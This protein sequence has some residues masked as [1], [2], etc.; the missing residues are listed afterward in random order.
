V[1]QADVSNFPYLPA[2][3]QKLGCPSFLSLHLLSSLPPFLPSFILEFELRALN[4]VSRCSTT[5]AMPPVL[6]ALVIFNLFVC[7]QYWG[8]N[9]GPCSVRVFWDRFLWTICPGW[10]QTVIL[11]I[12]ASWGARIR[13][14]YHRYP[15][16][17]G[18]FG[19]GACFWPRPAWTVILSL[20]SFHC[21]WDD[22]H[23]PPRPCFCHW[24]GAGQH[25]CLADMELRSSGF[26]PLA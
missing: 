24:V 6:F 17:S 9:S 21:H 15:A 14:M 11:L 22:G 25:F 18:Y 12:S 26:Q 2:I 20:Y 5:W 7:L 8:L 4:L 13:G 16:C 10:L 1:E 3:T 23:R 19:V